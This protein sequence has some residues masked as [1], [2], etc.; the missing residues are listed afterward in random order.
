MKGAGPAGGAVAVAVGASTA[1]KAGQFI[2]VEK[3]PLLSYGLIKGSLCFDQLQQSF[4]SVG[5]AFARTQRLRALP[6]ICS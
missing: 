4:P 2:G 3:R 1:L 5:N 6:S